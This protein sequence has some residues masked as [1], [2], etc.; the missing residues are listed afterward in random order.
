[1]RNKSQV[2]RK[3]ISQM[4][5]KGRIE[6]HII[7][8]VLSTAASGDLPLPSEA[9]NSTLYRTASAGKAMPC[10]SSEQSPVATKVNLNVTIGEQWLTAILPMIMVIVVLLL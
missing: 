6:I 10:A 8:L 1:M 9:C 7:H 2:K 5:K 3:E 4:R